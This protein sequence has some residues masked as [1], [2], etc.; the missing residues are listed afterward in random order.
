MLDTDTDPETGVVIDE[1][2]RFVAFKSCKR[3]WDEFQA[4]REDVKNVEDVD[5]DQPD[6]GYDCTRYAFMSRP[7][8]PKRRVTVP[9]GSFAAERGRYIRAKQYAQRH[10]VSM[11]AAYSRVR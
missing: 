6:E 9:P 11:S 3:W 1:T 10:G 5:T 8:I 7:V 2:P 4:L